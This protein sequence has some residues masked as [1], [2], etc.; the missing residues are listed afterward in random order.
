[1]K[2]EFGVYHYCDWRVITK[3]MKIE[4]KYEC[5]MLFLI[6]MHKKANKFDLGVEGSEAELSEAIQ[7]LAIE[8]IQKRVEHIKTMPEIIK[9]ITEKEDY[10]KMIVTPIEFLTETAEFTFLFDIAK[11]K[12]IAPLTVANTEPAF[13][14]AELIFYEALNK[15]VE[16]GRIKFIPDDQLMLTLRYYTENDNLGMIDRLAIYFDLSKI[17]RNILIQ[18]LLNNN[19]VVSLAHVCTQGNESEFVTP[20]VK[21]WGISENYRRQ[22]NEQYAAM[23]AIRALWYVQLC[24]QRNW[25]LKEYS[26]DRYA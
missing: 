13:R 4:H 12:I 11:E 23:F 18:C 15:F 25:A 20:F 9:W 17:D 6:A 1:M 10:F 8:Y 2:R 5:A 7:M 24:L 16:H 22:E 26:F 3:L 19:L 14:E 21:F